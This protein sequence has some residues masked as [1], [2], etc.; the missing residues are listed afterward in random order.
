MRPWF[1]KDYFCSNPDGTHTSYFRTCLGKF[2][3]ASFHIKSIGLIT[4]KT[5]ADT[6]KIISDMM[7]DTEKKFALNTKK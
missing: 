7:A 5:Y 2:R 1:P 6:I 4:V 3:I